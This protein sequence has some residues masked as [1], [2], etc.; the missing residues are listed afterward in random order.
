VKLIFEDEGPGIS[1]IELALRDGYTTGSG[2]GLGLGGARRLSNEFQLESKP[3]KG[4][5]VEITKW[6]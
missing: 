5:R 3:G 6:K 2:L 4:T 1:D